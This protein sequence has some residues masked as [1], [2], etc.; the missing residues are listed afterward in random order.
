MDGVIDTAADRRL[1][2]ATLTYVAGHTDARFDAFRSDVANW[3]GDW[4]G[5][6]PAHLRASDLLAEALALARSG[7]AERALTSLYVEE[8]ASR[9]WEQSYSAAD[10][11]VGADMLA[12]YGY[13]EIVGKRGPFLSERI[14]AGVGVFAASV[15]YPAHR[16]RAEELYFVLAGS[17]TFRLDGHPPARQAAGAV[18]HVPSQL[19]HRITMDTEPMVVLYLWRGGD[20][21]EK[22]TFV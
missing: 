5:V 14:R 10:T 8:R 18:V 19:V 2:D 22:S 7:T 3:G 9:H 4:T 6:A 21:R 11:A 13:T 20:L 15:D 12:G 16:H 1:L 17:G